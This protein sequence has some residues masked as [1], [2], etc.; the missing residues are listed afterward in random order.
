M[1]PLSYQLELKLSQWESDEI[2]LQPAH[3]ARRME[4]LD[5]LDTLFPPTGP[6]SA[7]SSTQLLA[8]A[9][10][11]SALLESANSG[12]YHSIRIQI[13]NGICPAEFLQ[14]LRGPSS[15]VT[16]GLAYD[17]L[18]DLLAGVLQFKPPIEEPRPLSPDSVFYQPTP[19]RHIFHLIAATALQQHD[20]LVDLGSGLGHVPLL[21]S[22]CTGASAIGVE[23]DPAWVATATNCARSLNLRNLTFLAQDARD[24][25]LSTGTVFYLYTP[26]TGSTLSVVLESLRN[27]ASVRPIR[28][29]TF[30]PCT[31]EVSKQ[32]WLHPISS[33]ATDQITVFFRR[34]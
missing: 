5:Q 11:L 10:S 21:V 1:P 26:F 3:F 27:Q 4:I 20:I 12:L 6:A 28:I 23:L 33:P 31:F 30:G 2:L 29:C 7:A 34:A 16:R 8:R 14:L 13:Q 32:T 18:D 19:A 24:A 15:I 17:H 25:D 9:R 22:I